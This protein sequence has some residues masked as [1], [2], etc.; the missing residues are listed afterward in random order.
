MSITKLISFLISIVICNANN[1][2]LEENNFIHLKGEI[3]SHSS[4]KFIL[5]L[6]KNENNDIIIYIDSNGGYVN[7]GQEIIAA[8]E[9]TI[10]FGKN[11]F[12]IA[13]RAYSMGF[14]IFQSCP[15][16]YVTK[17]SVLMQHPIHIPVLSGSLQ[18]VINQLE[19]I[20]KENSELITFQSNRLEMDEEEFVKRVSHE[21]WISGDDNLQFKTADEMVSVNCS[22]EL[23]E[24]EKKT[25][26]TNGFLQTKEVVKCPLI[27]N[28]DNF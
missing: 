11:I 18:M 15:Y 19:L 6:N 12:C 7:Y 20:K 4:S 3:N 22:K 2:L 28:D 21:W 5:D 13:D 24:T 9:N 10:N 8:I 25:I 14:V 26:I 17:K 27:K 23:Y 1:I 16:R